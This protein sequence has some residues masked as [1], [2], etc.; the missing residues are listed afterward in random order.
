MFL[1]RVRL[2]RKWITGWQKQQRNVIALE[3]IGMM[4]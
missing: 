2:Y 4:I 1:N 3:A